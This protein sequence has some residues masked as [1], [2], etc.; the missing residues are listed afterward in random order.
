LH[1]PLLFWQVVLPV[2]TLPDVLSIVKL[3]SL[4]I[5]DFIVLK[6]HLTQVD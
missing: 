3:D 1:T 6:Y 2:A 4:G 5:W